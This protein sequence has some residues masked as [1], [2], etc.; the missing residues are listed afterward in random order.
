M[1]WFELSNEEKLETIGQA[2]VEKNLPPSVIEKDWWVMQTLSIIF[3]MEVG[4]HLVFKGGT[5]LSKA[6]GLIERFSEDIDLAID[7]CFFKY[8]G[9]LDKPQIKKLRKA[10]S[11]YVEETFCQD[12]IRKFQEKH[13]DGVKVEIVHEKDS[14][15]DRTINIFY[16]YLTQSTEY[17]AQRVQVEISCRSLREPFS[18][19][20]FSSFLDV[21]FPDAPFTQSPIIVPSVHPERT[22]LEKIFL[23]HENFHRI[24]TNRRVEHLS[25]HLYDIYQISKMEIGVNAINEKEL[26]QTIVEHRYKF[27]KISGVD[28]NLLQPQTIN[29]IPPS[30]MIDLWKADYNEMKTIMFS[31]NTPAPD[32]DEMIQAIS[33]FIETVNKFEWEM[34]VVFPLPTQ[35]N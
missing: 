27:S 33:E 18:N 9:E 14:D 2:S 31:E 25:R 11:A 4:Q 5:S 6:W 17:I 13:F 15:K 19:R 10:S 12:L 7:R 26:Y 20:T 21:C 16:P 22:F 34:D 28:Y 8:D 1:N 29:P 24:K 23:L 32:F 3:E 35:Q 30:D